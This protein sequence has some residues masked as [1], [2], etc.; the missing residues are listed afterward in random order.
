MSYREVSDKGA[1]G[2]YV[3]KTKWLSLF[4]VIVRAH[5]NGAFISFLTPSLRQT[6]LFQSGRFDIVVLISKQ[7]ALVSVKVR[8]TMFFGSTYFLISASERPTM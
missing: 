6:V 1:G 5:S 3:L 4:L 7:S 8:R 2:A